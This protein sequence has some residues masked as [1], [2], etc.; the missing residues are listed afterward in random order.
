MSKES[1][2]LGEGDLHDGEEV[3]EVDSVGESFVA[4]DL[5]V[6]ALA[7]PFAGVVLDSWTVCQM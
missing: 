3:E 2:S 1:E 6:D 4:H 5:F 7:Q